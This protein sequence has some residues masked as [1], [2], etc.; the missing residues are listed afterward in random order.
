MRFYVGLSPTYVLSELSDPL[1]LTAI[2][3]PIAGDQVL[4][5]STTQ[6]EHNR[7]RPAKSHTTGGKHAQHGPISLERHPH[8]LR[9]LRRKFWPCSPLCLPN[10]PLLKEVR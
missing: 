8:P 6:F 5:N 3:D 9:D 2:D 1:S 4:A 7:G 10:G